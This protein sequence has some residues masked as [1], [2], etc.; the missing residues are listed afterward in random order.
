MTFTVLAKI[1][2][3]IEILSGALVKFSPVKYTRYMVFFCTFCKVRALNISSH[4][5]PQAWLHINFDKMHRSCKYILCLFSRA[6]S[7]G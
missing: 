2:K 3:S 7:S 6:G 5:L 1:K 4:F